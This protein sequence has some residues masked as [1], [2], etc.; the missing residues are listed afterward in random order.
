MSA[1]AVDSRLA[2]TLRFYETTLGKK[3]IMAVT[4]IILFGF[5]IGHMVGN[6]QV[7]AGDGGEKINH[8]AVQ[9]RALGPLLWVVRGGLIVAAILHI[10]AAVQ[11]ARLKNAARPVGYV[12]KVNEDSSYAARTMYWSGPILLAFALYHLAHFTWVALPGRYEHLK[13]YQNIV[14]GFQQ[15]LISVFYLISM[16]FLCMHLYHGLYSM[17]QT[18]GMA[19]PR[20]S[21]ALKRF[22]QVFS[23]G[24]FVG[25]A[26]VPV[27][28]LIGVVR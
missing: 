22:A 4:G 24:L 12:R 20:W 28:V 25:F 27:A 18:L 21:G 5:L 6:L 9:L 3:A 13:P 10:V 1:I 23:L 15:P 16:L 11:L 26:A 2:R 7:F 14:Y 19:H 8:Y 17:F